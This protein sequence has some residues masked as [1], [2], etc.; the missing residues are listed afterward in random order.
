M[1]LLEKNNNLEYAILKLSFE[2]TLKRK[3]YDLRI[4]AYR[5]IYKYIYIYIYIYVY[6]YIYI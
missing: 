6:I 5:N 2:T 1:L 4:F 3:S